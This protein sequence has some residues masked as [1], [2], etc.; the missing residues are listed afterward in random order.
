MNIQ[1]K[2]KEVYIFDRGILSVGG[3]IKQ[4]NDYKNK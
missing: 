2:D 3:V 1:M 4:I